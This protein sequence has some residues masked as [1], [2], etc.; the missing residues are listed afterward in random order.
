MTY[1]VKCGAKNSDD[2]V[3]CARCSTSLTSGTDAHH[4]REEGCF[5]LPGGGAVPGIIFGLLIMLIG[6]SWFLG[7]NFWDL[8]WPLALIALGL[9]ILAGSLRRHL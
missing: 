4:R 8:F 6:L 9:L 5:G 1:C 2:A 7:F 3:M